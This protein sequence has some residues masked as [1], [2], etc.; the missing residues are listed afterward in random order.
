MDLTTARN[1]VRSL[2]VEEVA[3]S[4]SRSEAVERPMV[5]FGNDP[6]AIVIGSQL[7]EFTDAVPKEIREMISNSLLLAQLAANKAISGMPAGSSA[8]WREAYR[9]VLFSTGWQFE[10][11]SMGMQEIR[12][13]NLS[14]HEAIIPVLTALLGPAAAASLVITVLNGLASMS[15]DTP[16]ITLFSRSSRRASLNN[17]QIGHVD[18][19]DGAAPRLNLAFFDLS[20]TGEVTQVLFFKF[21]STNGLLF[22]SHTSLSV[23]ES[24]LTDLSDEVKAKVTG[25]LADLIMD[26]EI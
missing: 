1:F 12:E 9:N 14:V 5:T 24:L 18:V 4:Q 26:I 21:T 6:Q 3:F 17:F 23:N 11:A 22:H 19:P 10:G 2:N 7:A 13:Q 16:W 25:H 8:E 20:V 15:E